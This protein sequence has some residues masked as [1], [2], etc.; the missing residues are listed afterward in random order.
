MM[1]L[2]ALLAASDTIERPFSLCQAFNFV[3]SFAPF[4]KRSSGLV[5]LT[6]WSLEGSVATGA[7]LFW[8]LSPTKAES[9]DSIQTLNL[10]KP[11]RF[12][13]CGSAALADDIQL[14]LRRVLL[15]FC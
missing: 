1:S 13:C 6:A 10:N 9:A 7:N 5:S 8:E 11:E 14:V 3:N 4:S 15:E 2:A 12:P